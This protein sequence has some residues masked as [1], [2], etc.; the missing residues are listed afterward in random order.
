SSDAGDEDHQRHK[1][2][3][4]AQRFREAV[5]GK[6]C[7][8]IHF[9]VAVF[10]GAPGCGQDLVAVLEDSHQSIN[11][12]AGVHFVSSTS[13][14]VSEMAI[15]GRNRM[16]RKIS[17][18]KS[19]TLPS[20]VA[21]SQIVGMNRP[22]ADGVKSRCRLVITMTNRSSHMPR[23]TDRAT[24][25]RATGLVRIRRDHNSWGTSTLK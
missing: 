12:G 5:D 14:R 20:K 23:F 3:L 19:P 8:R 9:P 4:S 21:Q 15:I 25:K 6:R 16:N 11:I 7:V 22:Q 1:T 24:K 10:I 2:F 18:A 17:V 13:L